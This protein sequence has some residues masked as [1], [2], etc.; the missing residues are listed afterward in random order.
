MKPLAVVWDYDGT[1]MNSIY[2]NFIVT[3]EIVSYMN[4]NKEWPEGLASFENYVNVVSKTLD[5]RFFFV[6]SFGLT[7]KQ[8]SKVSDYWCEY[9]MNNNTPTELFDGIS[10]VV[11]KLG[12]VPHAICSLNSSVNIRHMLQ[13]YDI[14]HY[15]TSIIGFDNVETDQHKPFPDAFLQCLK[16]INIENEGLVYY[17]GD[18]EEDMH[19]ARNTEIALKQKGKNI[20]VKS[21]AA[22]YSGVDYSTWNI[23]PDYVAHSVREIAS[24]ICL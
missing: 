22:S 24:F 5:W 1:L 6:E 3:R 9:Q 13:K 14:E 10:E 16:S 23:K 12:N 4:P 15:F 19:F 2:K 20:S 18:H 11:K 8:A 7:E 17:I 21:I